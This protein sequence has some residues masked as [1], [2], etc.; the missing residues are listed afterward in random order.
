MTDRYDTSGNI[1]AQFEPGSDQRVLANKL[2]ITDPSEMDDIELDLLSQLYDSVINS[3]HDD[4]QITVGDLCEWHRRWLGNVYV[5]AGQYRTV[6]MGKGEFHFAASGQIARLMDK[7]DSDIL[8]VHTPCVGM[9]ENGL[10]EAI[11]VVH[12]ELILIHPFREGNGRLSR[13]LAN[14]MALQAGRP[15][16]DFTAWDTDKTAYFSAIQSGLD[17]YEPM[18]KLVRQVLRE[19]E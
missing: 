6:N 16:L 13:L 4:Q 18:K 9:S 17:D 12:I 7:L 11:A 1:E 15:E 3:I 8:S 14:V 2:G 10:V 5:W 19:A